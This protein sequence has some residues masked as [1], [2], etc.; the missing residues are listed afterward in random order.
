MDGVTC[1]KTHDKEGEIWLGEGQ[2]STQ[3]PHHCSRHSVQTNVHQVVPEWLQPVQG[4]VGSKAEDGERSVR[5]VAQFTAH[6]LAPEVVGKDGG[7]GRFRAHVGVVA[8]GEDVVVNQVPLQAVPV[9]DHGQSCREA[10]AAA[11]GA[12][13]AVQK[14]REPKKR[15]HSSRPKWILNNAQVGTVPSALARVQKRG[16]ADLD[17]RSK[18]HTART[19]LYYT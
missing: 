10:S 9:A 15:L 11:V 17:C 19:T 3:P 1:K 2:Q 18:I 5:L 16:G 12:Q 14:P 7:E 13:E 4:V 8:N 6:R